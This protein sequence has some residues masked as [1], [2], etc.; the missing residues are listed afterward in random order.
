[1]MYVILSMDMIQEIIP[2]LLMIGLL[3]MLINYG[4]IQLQG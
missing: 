2:N 1:M 4:D 3:E